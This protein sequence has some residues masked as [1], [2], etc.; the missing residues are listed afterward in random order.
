M[1]IF[2]KLRFDFI[3]KDSNKKYLKYAVGEII[4]VVLGILIALQI[5]LWNEA[6]KSHNTLTLNLKG[7]LRELKV[8]LAT[9]E[10]II[11]VYKKVNQDRIAFINAENYKKLSLGE[12]EEKLENFTKE[13]K[14]QYSYFKKIRNSGITQFGVY[15][16]IMDNLINY[17]DNLIPYLN[18]T[19]NT[20]DAQ[21]I[22]E[23]E[24]WRYEQDS[25]EFN[26][27]DGLKSYQT[28]QQ[29]KKALIKLLKSPKGRTI[30]K[31]DVRR[32]LFMIDLLTK[33]KPDLEKMIVDLEKA[34]QN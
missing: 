8:D 19:I 21:V 4:L 14:L 15:T 31:I 22:R 18:T 16:E 2:R 23:D 1:K 34:L 11:E 3:K 25:Y 6:R 13:P 24:Y 20:Y 9:V 17:Y 5:N 10:E 27:L 28:E 12:L 26:L 33:L 30:L 7:V 32:N 29:A